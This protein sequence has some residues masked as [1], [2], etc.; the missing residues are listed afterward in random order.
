MACETYQERLVD[1]LY[2]EL[3]SSERAEVE[4]HLAS[5][6]ACRAAMEQLAEGRSLLAGAAGGIPR[7]PRVVVLAPT[8]A[9]RPW[10]GIAAGAFLAGVLASAGFFAGMRAA[11]RPPEGAP[12][13]ASAT[14]SDLRALEASFDR[15]LEEQRK[16]MRSLIERTEPAQGV[17]KEDLA[18]AVGQLEK[19]VDGWR[20]NDV[21]YL[22]GQLAAVDKR[23]S[24]QLGQTQEA[25]RYVALSRDPRV[26][27]Q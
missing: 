11:E 23:Q 17:R 1:L 6:G 13:V 20:A 10:V 19:K 15:R 21:E 7:A 3:G 8:L 24:T 14:P 2:D 9:R 4:A 26:S 16:E 12:R 18:N 22:L 25:L 5:C 27:E